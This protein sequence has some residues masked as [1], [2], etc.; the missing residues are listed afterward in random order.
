MTNKLL[1]LAFAA[2]VAGCGSK[3][4][5]NG[6][7]DMGTGGNGGGGGGGGGMPADMAG[8]VP[9]ICP[10][11][12]T[13]DTAGVC[14]GGNST[15]IGIDVK[16]V[17]VSG[18]VT[19]NGTAPSTLPACNANPASSKASVHLVDAARGYAFD[20]PVPCSAS[21]FSW[22]GVVF[23]GAYKVL[24]T[25]DSNFS[26]LPSQAFV[27]NAELDVSADA[28]N[29]ALDVKTASVG[30]TVTLNGAAP[31]T[32]AACTGNAS[33]AKATV[34]LVDATDGYRFDLDVP[35]SSST[36]Q[37]GGSVF[38]GTYAVSVD[39]DPSYSNVPSS[40][41][42]AN[43]A[44]AVS[45]T[46]AN[47][48]L[49]IKTVNA[50]G[51][52]T[53]NGAAPTASCPAVSAAYT[54][55][56]VHLSDK[57]SGY[58]FDIP[59]GCDQTDWAWSGAVFPGTYAVSVDGGDGYSNLPQTAFVANPS[60]AVNNGVSGQAL[61]VKTFTVSGTITLNGTTPAQT[62]F[63]MGDP[64][65]TQATVRLTDSNDG[66]SF[67]FDVLCSATTLAWT[68][69][70]FPGSYRIS[71]A[72]APSYST[73][74]DSA[75]VAKD[76]MAINAAQT[77]IGLDVKTATVGGTIT[78]NGAAPTSDPACSQ[79]PT[80]PK[81]VVR[82]TN[83]KMG[84]SFD[85]QVPCSSSTFAWT[86]DVFP[87][88]YAVSV[89]GG[90]YSNLPDQAFLANAALDVSASTGNQ[91]LDVKTA[92][93]GG[94]LTLNGA[95]PSTTTACNPNP[96]ADK[97]TIAFVDATQG[98]AFQVPVACSAVNFAWTGVVYPGTYR[99]SVAGANGYSN[100]PSEGFLVTPRLK[101]Q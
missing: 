47:Q 6:G 8:V 54:K 96:T 49:D 51:T 37:W 53:L 3:S 12:F 30:G 82:L 46:V 56:V 4:N 9:C 16:T 83:A 81:A 1:A 35:C 73:L 15:A 23:P 45:G 71:V 76:G 95:A 19:L 18:T 42:V 13:C 5:N 38:P 101:V 7:D 77:S 70:I 20:L 59:V 26:S 90:N 92:N 55:A 75:F 94:T 61:D 28:Q 58:H 39:G 17:N 100:L 67:S 40:P 2:L 85:L 22:S 48:A 80:Q 91:A 44:L 64:S 10:S 27:A 24:V 93:V 86:G 98:Y 69:T 99:I 36:F 72:G 60:L 66:Y 32:T 97:A 57:K 50:A 11:G 31:T 41:F 33:A 63:C 88:T 62:Q 21:T 43:Q 78:L 87:G 34:H 25:G 29:L 84:Y 79:N 65:A 52:I 68:G 74:P 89:A 14:V